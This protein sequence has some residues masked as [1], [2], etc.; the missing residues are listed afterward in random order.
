VIDTSK[1]L[2]DQN[3]FKSDLFGERE[4]DFILTA[5]GHPGIKSTQRITGIKEVTKEEFDKND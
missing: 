1:D 2:K 5:W 3:W 4:K